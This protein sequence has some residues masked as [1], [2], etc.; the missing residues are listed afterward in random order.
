LF[1]FKNCSANKKD[2]AMV[3]IERDNQS[4]KAFCQKIMLALSLINSEKFIEAHG[5]HTGDI[6]I[7][8][9]RLS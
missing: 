3:A 9:E 1:D 4:L 8:E 7:L 6:S 5:G 2:D